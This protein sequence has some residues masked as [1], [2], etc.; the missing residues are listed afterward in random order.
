M[1]PKR[2][3]NSQ[4]RTAALRGS[5][6]NEASLVMN[7]KNEIAAAWLIKQSMMELDRQGLY[8]YKLPEIAATEEQIRGAENKLRLKLDTRYREFLSMQTDGNRFC[9][10]PIYLEQTSCCK[11]KFT[12]LRR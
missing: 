4:P 1:A 8:S 10:K 5:R 7:W 3:P 9:R 12:M 6:I 11:E 2:C